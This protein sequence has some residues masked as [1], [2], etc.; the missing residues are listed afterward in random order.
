MQISI[1]YRN[2]TF[3]RRAKMDSPLRK[4]VEDGLQVKRRAADD[5]EDFSASSLLF[6][7]FVAL[8]RMFL[9]SSVSES[10]SGLRRRTLFDTS[11]RFVDPALRPLDFAILRFLSGRCRITPP[12]LR[13]RQVQPKILGND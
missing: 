7:G 1:L 9:A 3:I 11:R 12:R 10:T 5:F 13:A 8:S 2:D 4:R 6:L